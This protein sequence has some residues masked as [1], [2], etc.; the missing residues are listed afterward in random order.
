M[1]SS[2]DAMSIWKYLNFFHDFWVAFFVVEKILETFLWIVEFISIQVEIDSPVVHPLLL[3]VAGVEIPLRLGQTELR[4]TISYIVVLYSIK[5]YH[6]REIKRNSTL[7]F[8]EI[9]KE[10]RIRDYKT[11][12]RILCTTIRRC[13][14][15]LIMS[16]LWFNAFNVQ[17]DLLLIKCAMSL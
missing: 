14:N 8:R 7:L 5:L 6:Q 1:S 12:Q 3:M 15:L 9:S 17:F 2:E 13:S 10:T 4:C 11:K 16:I